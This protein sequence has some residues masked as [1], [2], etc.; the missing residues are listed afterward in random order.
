MVLTILRQHD[1]KAKRSKCEFFKPELKFMSHLISANGMRPDPA[2]VSSVV[3][4]PTPVSAYEVRSFLGLAN[5]FRKY[6]RAFAA[7]AAPLTALLKGIPTSYRTG[8]L[9]RW[10]RLPSAMVEAIKAAFA[11]TWSPE[12]D[13]CVCYVEASANISSCSD[14]A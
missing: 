11:R 3:D 4:C 14:A 2:K 9:L 13:F 12:C 1:L 8:M 6:I 10:G 7:T 5:Y